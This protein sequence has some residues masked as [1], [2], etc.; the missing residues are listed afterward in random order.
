MTPQAMTYTDDQPHRAPDEAATPQ[1]VIDLLRDALGADII[2]TGDMI[3]ERSLK[4][5]S[6][7]PPQMPLALLRP[8]STQ[9]LAEIM[10][11]CHT[12]RLPVVPQGG[13]TGLAGGAQPIENAVAISLERMRKICSVD[14]DAATMIVEAGVTLAEAQQAADQAGLLLGLDLGARGSCTIGGNLSTNAGGNN[15]IRYG[16]ARDHVLGLEVV[17]ADGTV[18]TSL[19]TMLKNNAGYDLKQL[20]IGSEGTLGIITRAVLRLQAKPRFRSVGFCGCRDFASVTRLLAHCRARL[21]PGLTGFEVMWPSFYDFMSTNLANIRRPF[22]ASHGLYVLMEISGFDSEATRDQ[23]EGALNEAL[24]NDI[25]ADV[26]IAASQRDERDLW[27][28][29]DGVAEFTVL[30]GPIIS[31][32]VSLPLDSMERT[33][34]DIEATLAQQWPEMVVMSFGHIGDNNLHIVAAIPTAGDDQPVTAVSEIVYRTVRAENGTISA[35]H[36]IGLLKKPYLDYCRSAIE[37]ALMKQLKATFDP[38]GILNPG[39]VL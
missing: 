29:R 9:Q 8:R 4:D 32:D 15:V 2:V 25:V 27:A 30:L 36:G 11:L 26:V 37:I 28:V 31:F 7:L 16:M 39:K 17:L 21:G 19:N 38:L 1:A 3:P 35:E 22:T 5:W 14:A 33:V 23:L 20:F 24:E 12:H 10:K 18:M 6:G 34:A 13:M